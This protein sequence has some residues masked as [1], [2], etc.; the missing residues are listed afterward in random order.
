MPTISTQIQLRGGLMSAQ[1]LRDGCAAVDANKARIGMSKDGT[2]VLYTGRAYL[3]HPDQSRRASEF[4]RHQCPLQ[5][6]QR[7]HHFRL[8]D[9]ISSLDTH[10]NGAAGSPNGRR[11]DV[12]HQAPPAPRPAPSHAMR[13]HNSGPVISRTKATSAGDG[14][15]ASGSRGRVERDG[16][17]VVKS[18]KAM[19]S[20]AVAH[21]LAM[22]NSHL[23]ASQRTLPEAHMK[24]GTLVMPYIDGAAPTTDEVKAA[25]SELFDLGFM[26]G[27]PCPANFVKTMSGSVVPVDF[28][29]MFRSDER[30][31]VCRSV[32]G[33]IVHDFIKGGHR[34]V[35]EPLKVQYL[36]AM[37]EFDRALAG[38][39]PVRNINVKTLKAAGWFNNKRSGIDV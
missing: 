27:D 37:F 36:H 18:F 31:T 20:D 33:E 26:I 10:A 34:F 9:L 21:E 32:M 25:V 4:L 17:Q 5:T 24:D 2:L 8:I 35:P 1:V 13:G 29:L 30:G 7:S 22:C 23:K 38:E 3:L 16:A 12:T 39:S 28:G 19:D 14:L 11:H 15:I 6:E